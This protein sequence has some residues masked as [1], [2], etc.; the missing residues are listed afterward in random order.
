MTGKNGM[1]DVAGAELY[2]EV[3]GEGR[4]L[5][6]LHDGLLDRRAWDGLFETFSR[7][8]R[9]VR[10]DRRGYGRS[11]TPHQPFSDVS[12]LHHL[13]Q[14]LEIDEA[15]LVGVSN[16][17]K[18][19]LEFALE[20]PEIVGTMVLVGP[21][22]DGYRPS[23]EKKRRVASLL[24]VAQEQGVGAGVDAWMDDPFY[25]PE[26]EKMAARE[27]VRRLLAENL[28]R[29]L[30]VPSHRTGPDSPVIEALPRI[31]APALI[32]VGERDDRDNLTIASILEDELPHATKRVIE[33]SGHLVNLETPEV[34]E[35]LTRCWIRGPG[36]SCPI[37]SAGE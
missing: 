29:L 20:H 37:G 23:E 31:V 24:S 14:H 36:L 34:F 18:V 3:E 25:P 35:R 21:N 2:C 9:T 8:Y 32:L 33:G 22:L 13:L 26:R 4:V 17:G 27:K 30:S 19:A 11:S 7:L 5:V 6:L 15:S 16:G 12:D 10:Y 1:V 28:P